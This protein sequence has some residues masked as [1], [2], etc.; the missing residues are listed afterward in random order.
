M[1]ANLTPQYLKAEER[2]QQAKTDQEKLSALEEM[3][4]TVPKHKGTEKLQA[5]LKRRISQIKKESAKKKGSHRKESELFIVKEG[6]GQVVILGGPNVGKSQLLAALTAAHPEI[7]PYPYTTQKVLPGMMPYQNIKIQ[8]VDTPAISKEYF[9]T[10]LTSLIR[11][12]DLVLLLCNLSAA[13][14][15]SQM[16]EVTL[17]LERV[18]LKLVGRAADSDQGLGEEG[19]ACKK[20]MVI[21]NKLESPQAEHNLAQ[22]Q[23]GCQANF[24]VLGISVQQHKNL[25]TLKQMIY[26]ELDIIR[27]YTK[28][29]GQEADLSDPVVLK[30]GSKLEDAAAQIHKDFARKL[31]YARVWGQDKYAG[32]MLGK[33]DVLCDGD[34]VEFHI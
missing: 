17:E 28:T 3:L 16:A 20:T 2:Y 30:K 31:R 15:S 23:A 14:S 26:E 18:H 22:L 24:Q 19:F 25:E 29:P 12:A 13:D 33:N 1:P 7:A 5:D 4:S 10:E 27:V 9:E 11:N 8:L 21:G 6:A 34:I 32:Q